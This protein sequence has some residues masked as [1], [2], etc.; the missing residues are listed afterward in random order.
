MDRIDV[1]F[2]CLDEAEALPSLLAALPDG[3]R[4][5]VVD[6]GSTDGSAAVARAAGVTVVSEPRRGYGAAV[7]A[8]LMVSTAEVVV[9]CDADGTIS[10]AQFPAVVAPIVAGTADL[11]IGRR[12]PTSPS[13][14]PLVPRAANRVLARMLRT[15]TGTGIRDLGPVRAAYRVSLLE[16]GIEDRRS[17]YPVELFLSA[18]HAGWRVQQ[19]DVD[20]LPRIGR[21]KV[22]GTVSGAITA[23]LD[24]RRRIAESTR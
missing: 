16:L 18:H 24:M 22:T 8:G 19:V 9:V 3:Y 14:W 12:R 13:A 15:R 5:I 17:G 2:P 10:P 1:V 6:N 20:Y 7:H 4:A 21:S 11:T 23:V